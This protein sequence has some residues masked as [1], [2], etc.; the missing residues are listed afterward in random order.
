MKVHLLASDSMG[1][2]SMA[3]CVEAS[4]LRVLIDPG[5]ALG[6]RRYGLP[7]HPLEY[8]KLE[9]DWRLI[10]SHAEHCDVLV[11]THYHYDH[12]S[13]EEPEIYRDKLVLLK[14]PTRNINLSQR[15][16]AQ[17]F[18]ERLGELP[19]RVEYCDGRSFSFGDVELIFSPPVY[20]GTNP[21]L[22]YV[23]EVAVRCQGKCFLF[24]SDIEGPSIEEQ[25]NFILEQNPSVAYIDGPM[26]YMLG[27][28]YSMKS[29]E[30][31]KQN[32]IR[33]LRETEVETLVL[34]HHLLRD[35]EWRSKLG[36]VF[37]TAEELGKRVQSAA[38]FA[39]R[40]ELMLEAR[41]K[42]LYEKFP[43]EG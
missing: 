3:C 43:V 31:T 20:H 1:T 12:H 7:P 16:R 18:L 14:H 37:S 8:Q 27:Y 11:V 2:R 15:R 4:G 34:D 13:P 17:Y 36:E 39:G 26:S 22:G 32:L 6:P 24:S 33:V 42:E 40:E 28:R 10:K 9:E 29:F 21:R 35:L 19:E 5:V 23:T 25:V 30:A 41:R 38:Q